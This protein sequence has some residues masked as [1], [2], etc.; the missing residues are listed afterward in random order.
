MLLYKFESCRTKG[1]RMDIS[2]L[3][4]NFR[5]VFVEPYQDGVALRSEVKTSV[6]ISDLRCALRLWHGPRKDVTV[7]HG[8]YGQ[9][10]S[11]H[12]GQLPGPS[13]SCV[14]NDT[15]F[16]GALLGGNPDDFFLVVWRRLGKDVYDGSVLVNLEMN[17]NIICLKKLRVFTAKEKE[18]LQLHRWQW[19][20]L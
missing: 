17:S 1:S 4:Q 7:F 19:R 5:I 16:N 8:R 9:I 14:D 20:P 10:Q 11:H 3:L 6:V 15:G 2:H 13:S 12:L 18:Y